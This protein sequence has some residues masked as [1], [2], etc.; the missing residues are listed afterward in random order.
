MRDSY[1]SIVQLA[2]GSCR[3][4]PTDKEKSGGGQWCSARILSLSL[5][6]SL[7]LRP[8]FSELPGRYNTTDSGGSTVVSERFVFI[9]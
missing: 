8:Y 6:H 2:F 4:V 3:F 9:A 1:E 5:P 7:T